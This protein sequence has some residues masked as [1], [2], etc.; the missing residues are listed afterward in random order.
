MPTI[1]SANELRDLYD[2]FS[3][4]QIAESLATSASTVRRWRRRYQIVSKPRGPRTTNP[5]PTKVSDG[6]LE[7]VIASSI[8]RTDL[9]RNLGLCE[10]GSAHKTIQ[11]RIDRGGWDTSHWGGRKSIL[12]YAGMRRSLDDLLV[13][14]RR[15]SGLKHRLV[16]EG[17]LEDRC[18][19]EGCLTA[20]VWRGIPLV[21]QLDHINGDSYDNRRENLR[22]LCP[23]CHSQTPTFAGRNKKIK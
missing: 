7:T 17:V 19:A 16:R 20:P 12:G 2:R 23:N 1:P 22:L 14:G 15:V 11:E 21:L 8:N 18:H 5:R 6:M 3:D 9:L 10:T 4:E 13:Q